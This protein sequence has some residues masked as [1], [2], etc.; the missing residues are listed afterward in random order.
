MIEIFKELPSEI[1]ACIDPDSL[2][3]LGTARLGNQM[4]RVKTTKSQDA[5]LK[6]GSG[7]SADD[8]DEEAKRLKWLNGRYKSPRLLAY[9]HK[10][11]FSYS[12]LAWVGN[13]AAHEWIDELSNEVIIE[14]V[15]L[16]ALLRP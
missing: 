8:I 15:L 4:L 12:V 2:L 1:R 9:A 5:I 6:I 13:Q 3:D 7:L 10:N 11:L 16:K 14:G